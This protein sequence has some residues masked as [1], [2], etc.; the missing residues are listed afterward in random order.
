MNNPLR[1]AHLESV[2]IFLRTIVEIYRNW[3]SLNK[4]LSL[5][6]SIFR[7]S[8]CIILCSS[9]HSKI[10]FYTTSESYISMNLSIFFKIN[11]AKIVYRSRLQYRTFSYIF[12]YI[13]SYSKKANGK[14]EKP[15]STKILDMSIIVAKYIQLNIA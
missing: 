2:L 15:I 1:G 3:F 6:W 11:A 10:A 4:Y 7:L 5:S 8:V 14:L 12:S 9:F 13:F